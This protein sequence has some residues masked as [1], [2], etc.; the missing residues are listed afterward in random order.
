MF[1]K[2]LYLYIQYDIISVS[3]FFVWKG[4]ETDSTLS[5]APTEIYQSPL[6]SPWSRSMIDLTLD[7]E[8]D[9]YDLRQRMNLTLEEI[10]RRGE[11]FC[12]QTRFACYQA[13]KE[14]WE[15]LCSSKQMIQEPNKYFPELNSVLKFQFWIIVC[16][17]YN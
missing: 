13:E 12:W 5:L 7:S 2:W 3:S 17:K 15:S 1:R 14:L 9:K 11:L 8:M 16:W 10:Q 6:D 4:S